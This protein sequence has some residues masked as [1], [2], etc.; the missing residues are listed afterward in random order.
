[1]AH[2]LPQSISEEISARFVVDKN[3]LFCDVKDTPR[4]RI[5]IEIGDSKQPDFKPQVKISRW[6]NEV[7]FSMRAEEHPGARVE[8][9][10]GKVK[11]ITPEYE[12]HQYE[13]LEKA[14]DEPM[15]KNGGVVDLVDYGVSDPQTLASLYE[16]EH[17][18]KT[19]NIISSAPALFLFGA[20]SRS[21]YYDNPPVPIFRCRYDPENGFNVTGNP[22]YIDENLPQIFADLGLGH[23]GVKE[24]FFAAVI[25]TLGRYQLDIQEGNWKIY[26]NHNGKKHKIVSTAL[27]ENGRFH[28][29]FNICTP[30]KRSIE[31]YRNGVGYDSKDDESIVQDG[32]REIIPDFS[33]ETVVEIVKLF[34]KKMGLLQRDVSPDTHINELAKIS[35]EHTP[36]YIDDNS[37]RQSPAKLFEGGFEVEWVIGAKPSSNV[38]TAS[39]QS[40]GLR[41]YYQPK[42]TDAEIV[43]GAYRP[44]NVEGSYAIYYEDAQNIADGKE[45]RAGKFGHIYRPRAIDAS[46]AAEWCDLSIENGVLSVTVPNRFLSSAVYP[47]RVDPTFGYTTAGSSSISIENRIRGSLFTST[48]S[49]TV[50]SISFCATNASTTV[51]LDM[52]NIYSSS[53][54]QVTN[55]QAGSGTFTSGTKVWHTHSYSTSPSIS[56]ADYYLVVWCGSTGYNTQVLFY[57]SGASDQGKSQTITYSAGNWPDPYNPDTSDTK[58][59]SIYA[60]Y[61]AGG[62]GTAVKDIIGSGLIPFAR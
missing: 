50:D 62:G 40:K 27:A 39:V 12:V 5:Q 37:L 15:A 16:Y 34:I 35:K 45:Y 36:E 58:K 4:D 28:A 33:R 30:Y 7:N 10:G 1:M 17:P 2:N 32:I 59:Y 57:D 20:Y 9:Q 56:A 42:L 61:T 14:E 55:G 44:I 25:E 53:Y 6:D 29:Y 24:A 60:T 21:Y 47:V 41:Y 48:E 43:D 51:N 54:N 52:A 19:V 3:T 8:T 18:R 49:G 26:I 31:Y 11:Y 13:L 46:G 23:K 22:M 38:F